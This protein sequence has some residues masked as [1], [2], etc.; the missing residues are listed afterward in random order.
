MSNNTAHYWISTGDDDGSGGYI[1][2]C[3]ETMAEAETI[4]DEMKS[5]YRSTEPDPGALFVRRCGGWIGELGI[6]E[7]VEHDCTGDAP[8]EHAPTC[9]LANGWIADGIDGYRHNASAGRGR[10][11][12]RRA[13]LNTL[14]LIR[15]T[16][17]G[18]D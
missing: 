15:K 8:H 14:S 2:G 16:F 17:L 6:S 3:F 13:T 5:Y 4:A 11:D 9:D 18:I 7:A 1:G 10:P 12:R